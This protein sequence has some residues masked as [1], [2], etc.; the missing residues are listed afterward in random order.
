M[1]LGIGL[2]LQAG[3]GD[4][5]FFADG[6]E[7]ILQRAAV[8]GVIE[9]IV[10]GD[11]GRAALSAD[12]AER[13][14]ARAVLAAIAMTG[15][16]IERGGS[17]LAFQAV[18]RG[19][20]GRGSAAIPIRGPIGRRQGEKDLSLAMVRHIVQREHAVAFDGAALSERQEPAEPPIGRAIRWQT[21]Q[22]R[23]IGKV[24]PRPDDEAHLSLLG[25]EISARDARQGIA[26]RDRNGAETERLGGGDQLLGMRSTLQEGEIGRDLKF[27][28]RQTAAGLAFALGLALCPQFLVPRTH[29]G[30]P[31]TM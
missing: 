7:H 8:W 4:R 3:V 10:G 12:G 20:Q 11:H 29:N 9:H 23:G 18:Q 6:A 25:R 31:R 5:A 19:L 30:H 16:K 1:P 26:I 27:G 21:D 13:C 17:E 2:Q 28:I 22:A 24:E 15:G 14:D